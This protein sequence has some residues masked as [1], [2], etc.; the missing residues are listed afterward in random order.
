MRV[1]RSDDGFILSLNKDFYCKN[2]VDSAVR[3]FAKVCRISGSCKGGYHII[4]FSGLEAG[5]LEEVAL[6]F[7]NYVLSVVKSK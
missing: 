6:E 7:A 3:D 4:H 1:E 2:A 5:D